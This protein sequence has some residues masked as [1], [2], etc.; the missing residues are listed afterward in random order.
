MPDQ[1]SKHKSTNTGPV[2]RKQQS[3]RQIRTDQGKQNQN[4]GARKSTD[5]TS[6]CNL[7]TP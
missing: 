7:S 1:Y 2:E 3:Y 5:R 6:H 4:L